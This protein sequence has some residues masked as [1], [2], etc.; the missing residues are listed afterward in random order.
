M[1]M[2][3]WGLIALLVAGA[4][5]VGVLDHFG[6]L[7]AGAMAMAQAKRIS[8]L[9]PWI[10]TYELGLKRSEAWE[11]QRLRLEDRQRLLDIKAAEVTQ[12]AKQLE[13]KRGDVLREISDLETRRSQLLQALRGVEKWDRLAK[14]CATLTA[15]KA[16]GLLAQLEDPDAV[17][18]LLRLPDKQMGAVLTAMDP[19]RAGRLL[20]WLA[21]QQ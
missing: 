21:K 6:F 7:D 11:Q 18:V 1:R 10:K 16:A 19:K 9:A 17:Q 14:V 15:A 2:F 12:Q 8:P 5:A 3:V 13:Q 20:Q 4:V